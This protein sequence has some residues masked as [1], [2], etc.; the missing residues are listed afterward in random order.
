MFTAGLSDPD[1]VAAKLFPRQAKANPAIFYADGSARTVRQVY[2]ALVAKHEGTPPANPSFV[3]QQAVGSAPP[4]RW[5]TEV[6]PPRLGPTDMSFETLFATGDAV[7]ARTP[8]EETPG[9]AFFTQL[10]GQ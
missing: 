4:S 1:Q 10:Y 7:P 6:V 2:R 8:E 9:G 3:A 5:P